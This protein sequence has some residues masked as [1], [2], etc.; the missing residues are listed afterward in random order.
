MTLLLSARRWTERLSRGN[1]FWRRLPAEFGRHPLK[2]SPDAALKFLKPGRKAFDPM[3]FR[4]CEDHVDAGR[5]VWDVGANVGIFSLAAAQR[6]A[7]V[8]AI[9][10]DPWL[11][12]L[13]RAS[14]EH[15]DNLEL[16]LDPI[17]VAVAAEA[18]TAHLAIARR[19]RASNFLHS[20]GGRNDAGGVRSLCLVPVLTL[21]L[22]LQG[23]PPP[24]LIKIDVEGAEVAVLNGAQTLLSQVRPTILVEVGPDTRNQVIQQFKAADYSVFDYETGHRCDRKSASGANLLARPN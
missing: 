13:L 15:P 5:V 18:G 20:F 6:K 8:L 10:P 17:C 7:H 2:V 14:A 4:L 1:T 23:Q 16:M 11:C 21:D 12:S 9:E 22:L 3:L 19:G 24:T